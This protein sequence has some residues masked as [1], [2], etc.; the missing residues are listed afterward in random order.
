MSTIRKR[1]WKTGGEE[2]VAWVCDY[3]DQ[4]GKRHIKTFASKGA[5]QAWAV[6][7]LHEVKQGTH[8]PEATSLTVSAAWE[9]WL[10]HCEANLERGTVRQREEHLKHHIA[11]YIGGEKLA[12]LTTPRIYQLDDQ[13]REAG[14][15]LSMRRKVITNIGV[16]LGFAQGRGLVS[17]NVARGVKIKSDAREAAGPLREGVDYPSRDQL[18]LLIDTATGRRRPFLVTA[19][20]TGMRAS[21]LRG[22]IWDDVD[23]TNG[24]IHVRRRAD[25][26]GTM[27]AP[28]SKMGARDIPLP[29]LV[30]NT[31][32]AWKLAC[33]PGPL[34]LVFPNTKGKV[35]THSDIRRRFWV[36]LLRKCGL[37]D[38]HFHS[39][40]HAF[41][42]LAISHLG[43]PVKRVQ[44]VLG[45]ASATMTLD[46][47]GH[48]F[49]DPE[50]DKAAMEKL[51][52]AIG[53]A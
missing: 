36:P 37:P 31:L 46:V 47:Y 50:G 40:R 2:R 44:V 24:I 18:K 7:A 6:T 30:I 48:L 52:A 8:T 23:L 38:Y 25:R 45:H 33:P 5:A 20:F 3:T 32:R 41:A 35:E 9:L 39:L 22:L 16:M 4:A 27:G 13:L 11:A 34:G 10:A 29:P 1:R 19:I 17:Q 42:S 26:W 51:Q 15:S 43:W 53:V 49:R 21:E 28:K 12:R 14:R